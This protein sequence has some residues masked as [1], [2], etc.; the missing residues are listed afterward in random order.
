MVLPIEWLNIPDETRQVWGSQREGHVAKPVPSHRTYGQKH[1]ASG[2]IHLLAFT[3]C[4][5]LAS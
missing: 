2:R 1:H 3:F 5:E 4:I